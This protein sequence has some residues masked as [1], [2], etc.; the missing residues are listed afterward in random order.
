METSYQSYMSS[1]TSV[2]TTFFAIFP[3]LP[4]EIRNE[5]WHFSLPRFRYVKVKSAPTGFLNSSQ[6]VKTNHR[7]RF[8]TKVP[9]LLSVCKEPRAVALDYYPPQLHNYLGG[10]AINLDYTTGIFY[11]SDANI[12]A[13]YDLISPPYVFTTLGKSEV[14]GFLSNARQIVVG[15]PFRMSSSRDVEDVR[16]ANLLHIMWK[17]NIGGKL[18]ASPPI[19]FM[20]LTQI[21]DM[22]GTGMNI[23]GGTFS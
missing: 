18:E 16:K 14:R 12:A 9:R 4:T 21:E 22:V 7:V 20:Q 6:A 3:K 10:F 8:S 19:C 2:P 17:E 15:G 1:H 13:M 11:F 5:I 23:F